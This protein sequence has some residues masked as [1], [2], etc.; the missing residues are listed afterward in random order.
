VLCDIPLGN[1]TEPTTTPTASPTEIGPAFAASFADTSS[2]TVGGYVTVL[3][4]FLAVSAFYAT[5]ALGGSTY[6][7]GMCCN[8]FT[9]PRIAAKKG[10]AA[11]LGNL[12]PLS[13]RDPLST[14]V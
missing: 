7:Y 2:S 10:N 4:L 14:N 11:A 1:A 12:R 9:S 5:V 8:T 3:L 13:Q 6:A